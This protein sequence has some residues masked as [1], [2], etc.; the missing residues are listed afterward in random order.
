MKNLFNLFDKSDTGYSFNEAIIENGNIIDFKIL[1]RSAKFVDYF[2]LKDDVLFASE[3][4]FNQINK[5]Y[6]FFNLCYKS[7]VSQKKDNCELNLKDKGKSFKVEIIPFTENHFF[8]LVT[9]ITKTKLKEECMA[10][11]IDRIKIHSEKLEKENEFLKNITDNLYDL[12]SLADL[13][14]YFTY[15]SDSHNKLGWNSDDLIG[16]NVLEF[17]H[18]EDLNLIKLKF[19]DFIKKEKDSII[20][21]YRYRSKKGN[22][23][24]LETAGKIIR[25]E[26][27]KAKELLFSSRDITEKKELY[28][29]NNLIKETYIELLNS[30]SE[31]VYVLD[32]NFCFLYVNEG[33]KKMYGYEVEDIIGKDP[34]YLSADGKNNMSFITDQMTK[35]VKDGISCR[36]E[37][38]GRKK[39]GEIFLKDVV[40]NKGFY[41]NK[42]VL[43]AV[44]RDITEQKTLNE[45]L[46]ESELKYRTIFDTTLV[47]I[48]EEDFSEVLSIIERLQINNIIELQNLLENNNR[49]V[50]ELAKAIKVI[51]VN[52]YSLKIFEA[53]T[54]EQLLGS[55]E[56]VFTS[57]TLDIVKQEILAIYKN[58]SYFYG[59]TVN[60]T[61]NGKRLELYLSMSL[62]SI[63]NGNTKATVCMIDIT[64]RKKS[65]ENTHQLKKAESLNRMAGAIAHNYNNLMQVVIGNLELVLTKTESEDISTLIN[66][67]MYASTRA[68]EISGLM[69]SYLGL[70]FAKFERVS[71]SEIFISNTKFFEERIPENI[72]FEYKLPNKEIFLNCNQQ[73]IIQIIDNLLLNSFES[74]NSNY[75]KI[76]ISIYEVSKFKTSN[77]YIMPINY[78]VLNY[79]YV[80]F[81]IKDNGS[82][83]SH[84]VFGKI[85]DPFYSTKFTGRGLGLSV[86]L[87]IVKSYKGCISL[88]SEIGKGSCFRVYLPLIDHL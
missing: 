12:V 52:K 86:V 48:W 11:D 83:I 70:S 27:G 65:E 71:I 59:E 35:T 61:V 41:F 50:Y 26:N 85:F 20:A 29:K 56:K 49:L 17:V 84:N 16:R 62:P 45:A 31:A 32:D 28:E 43:I 33:A 53:N 24:W 81:E 57:K 30:L 22:Y 54:K 66:N 73:Q 10:G 76:T 63:K 46:V 37:F 5:N 58:K 75:G 4:Y 69:L 8:L 18:P 42:P 7:I 72:L 15:T 79:N 6:N 67:A 34:T 14:G 78:K 88:D 82:G 40:V 9:N 68:S 47:A 23:F 39:N 25:D 64:E 36:F 74:I 80:C 77:S 38:W 60:R 55:L 87:G 21:I 13:K 19:S 1:E 3:S 2:D 44:S 51:D